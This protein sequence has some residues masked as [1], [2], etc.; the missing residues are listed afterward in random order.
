VV[1]LEGALLLLILMRSCFEWLYSGETPTSYFDD[2]A[3][4]EAS[5]LIE[6]GWIPPYIPKSVT[7]VVEQQDLDSNDVEMSFTYRVTRQKKG[8][9]SALE[10]ICTKM[11]N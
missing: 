9:K 5:G 8:V 4:V 7:H 2:Y 1:S 10:S 3:E 6:S 11:L